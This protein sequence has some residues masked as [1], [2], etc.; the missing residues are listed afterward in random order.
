MFPCCISLPYGIRA[1]GQ[2]QDELT[3]AIN[4]VA[5]GGACSAVSAM[6]LLPILAHPAQPSSSPAQKKIPPLNA[7]R[8]TAKSPKGILETLDV[9]QSFGAPA[10][11][12]MTLRESDMLQLMPV[13]ELEYHTDETTG[14]CCVTG[15]TYLLSPSLEKVG[16]IKNDQMVYS[17]CFDDTHMPDN[18]PKNLQKLCDLRSWDLTMN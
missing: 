14:S 4:K 7:Q 18:I 12:I 8:T 5:F 13:P 11:L 10:E 1:A 16:F 15:A 6:L 17:L 3:K 9:L 2:R